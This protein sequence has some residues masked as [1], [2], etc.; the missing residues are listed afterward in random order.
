[1]AE[2]FK[3]E[4]DLFKKEARGVQASTAEEEEALTV[5]DGLAHE[6]IFAALC[7]AGLHHCPGAL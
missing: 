6:S 7:K 2:C 3:C 1:M 4:N 5:A